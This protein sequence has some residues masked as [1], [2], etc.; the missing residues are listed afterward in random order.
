MILATITIGMYDPEVVTPVLTP[1]SLHEA[2]ELAHEMGGSSATLSISHKKLRDVVCEMLE[3]DDHPGPSFN[4]VDLKD[5]Q[6]ALITRYTGNRL[7]EAE[8]PIQN[9]IR[10]YFVEMVSTELI[11]DSVGL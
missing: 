2:I 10:F 9:R 1:L 4:S 11:K 7:K 5:G 3:L 6:T 8:T